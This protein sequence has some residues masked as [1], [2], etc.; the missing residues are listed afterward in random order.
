MH[1]VKGYD[2]RKSEFLN[3]AL[4]LFMKHGYENTSVNMIIETVGVSKG[5]FYHYFK[6]KEDLMDELSRRTAEEAITNLIPLVQD[7]KLSALDKLNEIFSKTNA[8]KVKNRQVFLAFAQI[9]YGDNN[10]H[11]RNR[12]T[13]HS[14]DRVAPIME[15][16]IIQGNSEGTMKVNF[17][18]ETAQFILQIGGFIAENLVRQIMDN[19]HPTETEKEIKKILQVYNISVERILGI[20]EG[21]LHL[22]DDSI[23]NLI[24]GAYNDRG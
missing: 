6:T 3:T 14:V 5:A 1:V 22:V 17:P 2:E 13:R 8:F 12:M 21:L 11:L 15:K 23:I 4:G 20:Q 18:R 7:S 9:Y 24:S 19:K 10:I 16:I